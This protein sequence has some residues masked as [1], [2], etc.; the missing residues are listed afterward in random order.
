MPIMAAGTPRN[1][2]IAGRTIV[3][4]QSRGDSPVLEHRGKFISRREYDRATR[5]AGPR[6]TEEHG[7]YVRI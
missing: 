6:Y 3:R 2:D 1:C 4:R 5:I 7:G